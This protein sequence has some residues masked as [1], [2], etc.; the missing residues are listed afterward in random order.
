MRSMFKRLLA[1][2]E[3]RPDSEHRQA[4]IRL[5]V[6]LSLLFCALA[7]ALLASPSEWPWQ[8]ALPVLMA[9]AFAG[10]LIIAH[11]VWRPGVSFPRRCLGMISDYA[12]LGILLSLG[13][14]TAPLYVL[15]LWLTLDNGVRYGRRF[16]LAAA[17]L[18]AISFLGAILASDYWMSTK[19]LSWALLSG[20][21]LIPACIMPLLGAVSGASVASRRGKSVEVRLTDIGG[22][23]REP[24]DAILD[25][26]E[27]LS[28]S[29]LGSSQREHAAD[30]KISA[31]SLQ[32]MIEEVIE[33]ARTESAIPHGVP[34][35][36]D[37]A[38]LLQSIERMMRPVAMKK[39]LNLEILVDQAVPRELHGDAGHIRRI[40]FYLT[41]NSIRHTER[42]KISIEVALRR[43]AGNRKIPLRFSVR[44]TRADIAGRPQDRF[45]LSLNQFDGEDLFACGGAGTGVTLARSLAES[46]G[47]SLVLERLAVKG[48]RFVVDLDI[49]STKAT[50]FNVRPARSANSNNVIA[51]ADPF[52]RHRA[53]V[54]SLDILIADDQPSSLS[55][56][57][58]LLE[59]AGHR[60]CSVGSGEEVLMTLVERRFDATIIDLHMPGVSG[61]ETIQQARIMQSGGDRTPI[62]VLSSD[63]TDDAVNDA[64]R[65]GAH[66]YLTKP[67]VVAQLLDAISSVASWTPHPALKLPRSGVDAFA[68]AQ[69]SR[70]IIDEFRELRLGECF[71]RDFIDECLDDSAACICELEKCGHVSDWGLYREHCHALK[72]VASNMGAVRLAQSASTWMICAN[73]EL[74]RNWKSSIG[75]LGKDL[76]YARSA[77]RTLLEDG[78]CEAKPENG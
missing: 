3:G 21:L 41:S 9:E 18:A 4:F 26:S 7:T 38:G 66:I 32:T 51:F 6:T 35:D 65:A 29:G 20:L 39:G 15:S 59:K 40:L 42:G 73:N 8:T 54:T 13:A 1:R 60:V 2:F 69:V 61:I 16:L 11:I 46:L 47:G 53:R 64:R 43:S 30:L 76:E 12:V 33:V 72:G 27:S 34:T 48:S 24:L 68:E 49:D 10:L 23:L 31:R 45:S 19:Q 71:I 75:E 70:Q 50:S 25:L 28:A 22:E 36:F 57:R 37:I 74:S 44:D 58:R 55:M 56:L 52:V 62:I 63:S 67:I 14:R 77:L 17:F 78:N 5:G